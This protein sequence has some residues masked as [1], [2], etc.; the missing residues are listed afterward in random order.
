MWFEIDRE[1]YFLLSRLSLGKEEC[2]QTSAVTA[3]AEVFVFLSLSLYV[4][5]GENNMIISGIVVFY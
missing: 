1:T 3:S 2:Q 5:L 4:V